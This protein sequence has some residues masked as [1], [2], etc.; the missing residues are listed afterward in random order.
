MDKLFT[1]A[2]FYN[3]ELNGRNFHL[4]AG[5]KGNVIEF[6]IKFTSEHFHHLAGLHKLKDLT[7][8]QGNKAYIFNRVSN[9]KIT[10]DDIKKSEFFSEIE[11][12]LNNFYK[13]KEALYGKELMIKSLHGEFNS[14]QADFML[15]KTD[16]NYGY[17]HLFLINK[18]EAITVPVTFIVHPNN[19][20]LKNNSER[21]TVLSVEEVRRAK[22]S[23]GNCGAAPDAKKTKKLK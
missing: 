21:W 23:S 12:R 1:A 11:N 8:V 16:K 18:N 4:K 19:D 17:A 14:I 3:S 9:G 6:D 13:I 10:I 15:T 22:E 5:K 20:Y 2:Q 7:R